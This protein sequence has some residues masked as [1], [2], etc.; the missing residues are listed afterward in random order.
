MCPVTQAA[1]DQGEQFAGGGD[2]GRVAGPGAAAGDDAV[3]DLSRPGAGGL[4]LDGLGDRPAQHPRALRGH[5]PPA[6]LSTNRTNCPSES[7]L[8]GHQLHLPW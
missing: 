6:H 8:I 1:E 2:L 7:G 5:V 4:P 3:F